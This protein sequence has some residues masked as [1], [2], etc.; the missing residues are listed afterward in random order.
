MQ[1]NSNSPQKSSTKHILTLCQVALLIALE[2]VLN[3]FGSINLSWCKIG[4][5]FVPM[6]LCGMLYGPIWAAA[7]YA[8]SD[9]LGAMLFPIGPYHPGFTLCAAAMGMVYGLLLRRKP[10]ETAVTL[11]EAK[12]RYRGI[13]FAKMCAAAVI[14]CLVIGLVINTGWVAQL[15]G[16][17]TY[18]GWF[19]YRLIQYA[20]L[21]PAQIILLPVLYN[22][23][24]M[25]QK[26]G[27]APAYKG[28]ATNEL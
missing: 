9:F 13:L 15:Y 7:A 28:K 27:L 2:I 4:L 21:V 20:V 18:W 1:K 6:A 16:S 5:S 14:N 3:R 25:L 12:G 24:A 26:N 11:D 22:L 23:V 8:V 19:A 10:S 17:K